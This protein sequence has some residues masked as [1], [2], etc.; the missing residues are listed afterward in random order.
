MVDE[1]EELVEMTDDGAE[2]V[3]EPQEPE[4][5]AEE[6]APEIETEN[7]QSASNN[8]ADES[9]IKSERG[10][11]RVQQLANERNNLKEEN[12][13]LRQTLQEEPTAVS[14]QVTPP[15][16]QRKEYENLAGQELTPEQYE[17]HLTAKAREIASIEVASLRKEMTFKNNLE[18]DISYLERTYE[19]LRG[20]IKDQSLQ[21]AVNKARDNFKIA[22]RADP[23]IRFRDFIEPLMEV[24]QGAEQVGRANA[25]AR[26]QEQADSGALK[27]ERTT[28]PRASSEEEL[29]RQ[30][31]SGEITLAEAEARIAQLQG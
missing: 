26:L 3:E 1:P 16:T 4:Q 18:Q 2:P 30:I 13:T 20:E 15:W 11:R 31:D 19:E 9:E 7:D 17:Q 12:Q 22:Q 25:S 5:T 10:Q 29:M 8:G 21:R 23:T 24:R 14:Q 6:S 27:T 28:A